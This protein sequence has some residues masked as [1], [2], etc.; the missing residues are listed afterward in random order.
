VKFVLDASV[1]LSWLLRDA[2]ARDEPYAFGVLKAL[3][4]VDNTA[5]VPETWGLEVANVIARCESKE[6]VT[7]AQSEAYLEMLHAADRR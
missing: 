3:R 7:E 1:A 4:A 2:S 6:Q 5:E